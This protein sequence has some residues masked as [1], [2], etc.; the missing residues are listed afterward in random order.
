MFYEFE[1]LA[2]VGAEAALVPMDDPSWYTGDGQMP[3]VLAD[4]TLGPA[5]E[6]N[7]LTALER[8]TLASQGTSESHAVAVLY[9]VRHAIRVWKPNSIAS[10]FEPIKQL[11]YNNDSVSDTTSQTISHKAAQLHE[12]GLMGIVL[13]HGVSPL[14]G[15]TDDRISL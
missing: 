3:L 15:Y 13:L 8:A 9:R 4:S 5:R 11:G 7:A 6:Y 10:M 12:I 2:D 1:K 14:I